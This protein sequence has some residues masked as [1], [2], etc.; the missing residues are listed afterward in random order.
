VGGE[1]DPGDDHR[2]GDYVTMLHGQCACGDV[3]YQ[4]DIGS[5]RRRYCTCV[6]C[7]LASGEAVVVGVDLPASALRWCA[8]EPVFYGAA[9]S[10]LRHG[11]CANC[12]SALCT[13]RQDGTLSLD[14][15]TLDDCAAIG[16]R[17]HVHADYRRGPAPLSMAL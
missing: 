14:V 8:G 17:S 11:F 13:L 3:R 2:G 10:Q 7:R 4:A 12:G 16:V 15:S 5:G 9:T 6:L 1:A